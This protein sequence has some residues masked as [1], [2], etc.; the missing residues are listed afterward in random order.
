MLE[1]F[2]DSMKALNWDNVFAKPISFNRK[3][4]DIIEVD[5]RGTVTGE[6]NEGNIKVG[7][8]TTDI[9]MIEEGE[10][11]NEDEDET[12]EDDDD[13][14]DEEED[15]DDNNEREIIDDSDSDNGEIIHELSNDFLS[16]DLIESF[17]NQDEN[18]AA[19]LNSF[20]QIEDSATFNMTNS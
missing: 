6:I 2:S 1:E 14:D 16:G 5:V 18:L 4:E 11:G 8:S 20:T 19:P 13:E 12:A 15:D 10:G 7:I 3:V 9:E 17:M